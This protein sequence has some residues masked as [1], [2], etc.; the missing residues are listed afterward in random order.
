MLYG[1]GLDAGTLRVRWLTD[2]EA[3]LRA[4]EKDCSP[5]EILG[6]QDRGRT[7]DLVIRHDRPSLEKF[8]TIVHEFIHWVASKLPRQFRRMIDYLLDGEC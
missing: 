2:E 3:K 5:A 7:G 4:E 8:D 1:A 6:F